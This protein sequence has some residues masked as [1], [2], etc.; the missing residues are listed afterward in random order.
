M[1]LEKMFHL[2]KRNTSVKQEMIAGLTTFMTMAYIIVV[3]PAIM[4]ATG[5][6][7]EAVMTTTILVS[8]F[9]TTLMA[10]L[11]NMPLAL[12]PGMGLNAF[13]AFTVVAKMG[14]SWQFAL[15]AVFLEGIIFIFLSLFRIREAII[16]SLPLTIRKA[17]SVGIG[18]FIAFIGL[19]NAQIITVGNESVPL[20]LGDLIHNH[21]AQLAL[22]GLILTGALMTLQVKGAILIGIVLTTIIGIP[23]GVTSPISGSP[24]SMPASIAPIFFQFEWH[25]IFSWD[26]AVIL[27]TM[28]F[29]DLF[30]TAG[31]VMGVAMKGKFIQKDG[32]IPNVKEI[33]LTDAIATTVGAMFGSSTVTTFVESSAGVSVG[34]RTGLTAL[35]VAGLFTISLFL[36]PLLMIVPA[37]ATSPALILVGLLMLSPILEIDLHDF[38][39]AL[40]AFLVMLIMPLSYSISDGLAFGIISF[41]LIKLLTK[42][43]KQLKLATVLLAL[44]FLA[45]Y[46]FLT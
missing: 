13:F 39:E 43:H 41:V 10:F 20:F 24:V 1:I 38:S 15:T 44:L 11:A 8:I 25:R 26:M 22:I 28:L 23:M 2:Q 46:I 37:A 35:T 30:D 36:S 31:T 6:P 7:F 12:A 17:I 40:P 9:A 14:Y 45:R 42:N 3:N 19:T 4:G 29:V 33:F 32:T 16:E 34:G 21:G 27:F 18:L 5:M